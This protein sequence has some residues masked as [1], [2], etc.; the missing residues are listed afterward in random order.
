MAP[1]LVAPLVVIPGSQE[2]AKGLSLPKDAIARTGS[3]KTC[4]AFSVGCEEIIA[5][6]QSVWTRPKCNGQTEL[7]PGTSS[8]PTAR[9]AR[10]RARSGNIQRR[11]RGFRRSNCGHGSFGGVRRPC[12]TRT[13]QIP[14]N[15]LYAFIHRC[16]LIPWH[17][18]A[19][20][21]PATHVP[22]LFVTYLPSPQLQI[23]KKDRSSSIRSDARQGS[24]VKRNS[25]QNEST[26]TRAPCHW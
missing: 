1:K 4:Q 20:R 18:A 6:V 26:P 22:G 5:A 2:V 7:A 17:A 11:P 8:S 13:A 23:A 3:R 21:R 12:L 19:C 25:F 15:K 9:A 10:I 16:S 24:T 14:S